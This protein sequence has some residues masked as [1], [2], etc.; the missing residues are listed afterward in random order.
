MVFQDLN[1]TDSKLLNLGLLHKI[2][3]GVRIHVV[4]TSRLLVL[5]LLE[6]NILAA[7]HYLVLAW[8]MVEAVELLVPIGRDLSLEMN[9]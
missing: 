6:D 7:L 9:L 4:T 2:Q 3:L 1:M 5:G 8:K